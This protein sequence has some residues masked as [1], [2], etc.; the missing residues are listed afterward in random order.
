MAE[1]VTPEQ[2]AAIRRR[3]TVRLTSLAVIVV[4]AAALALD[5]RQDVTL[6]YVVGERTAPLIIALVVAFVL[7]GIAGRLTARRSR[8]SRSS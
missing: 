4:A 5:N 1:Q 8:D 6:G 7:G 2:E 3:Q